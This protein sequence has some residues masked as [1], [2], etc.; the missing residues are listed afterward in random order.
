MYLFPYFTKKLMKHS[1][2]ILIYIYSFNVYSQYCTPFGDCSNGDYISSFSFNGI[3]NTSNGCDD[4]SAGYSNTGISFNADLGSSY[5][6][7]LKSGETWEQ[8]F[9]I[10]I[11]YNQDLDFD[12]ENE[13]VYRTLSASTQEFSGTITIAESAT[14]GTTRMRVRSQYGND[15]NSGDACLD[16][17]YGET[18]DYEIV[19]SSPSTPPDADFYANTTSTCSGTIL[20]FDNSSNNPTNWLWYFGDGNT[21]SEQNPSHTYLS[22]GNYT[23]SLVVENEFGR[24][25]IAQKDYINVN[26]FNALPK[27]ATCIPITKN[28]ND[29]FGI[30]KVEFNTI[31]N[32]SGNA[33][34][35]YEDFT[36]FSTTVLTGKYYDIN[37]VTDYPLPHNVKVWIDFNDDGSFSNGE[38]VIDSRNALV[39]NDSIEIPSLVVLDT[40]LRM[41]VSADF[42]QQ[43]IPEPCVDLENGQAEDYTII[44]EE[45][46]SPPICKF[47]VSEAQ[48]CDGS[49]NFSDLSENSPTY[50]FWDFG[51]GSTSNDVNPL[52]TY[53]ESGIYDVK[54]VTGNNFGTDTL[55]KE[56]FVTVNFNGQLIEASCNPTTTSPF[57]SYGIFGVSF[58]DINN[59]SG[60]GEENYQDYSC[61]HNT[62]IGKSGCYEITVRTGPENAEDVNVWIDFDNNGEFNQTE[63]VFA[64]TNQFIHSGIINISQE[65]PVLDTPLRMRVSSDFTGSNNGPCDNVQWGQVEDYALVIS[66]ENSEPTVFFSADVTETCDGG[67]QFTDESCGEP[68]AW[69]WVFG[70]GKTSNEQNPFHQY[71]SPGKYSVTLK[72]SNDQGTSSYQITNYINVISSLGSPIETSCYP[73]TTNPVD[74]A[75]IFKVKF[76]TIDYSTAG[77]GDSYEDYT[78]EQQAIVAQGQNVPISVNTGNDWQ[79]DVR[80]WID[81]NNDGNFITSELVFSS[82]SKFG[83]HVGNINIPPA[84]ITDIPLRMRILSDITQGFSYNACSEPEFGQIEDYTVIIQGQ[85]DT[86]IASFYAD[87]ANNCFGNVAFT[88]T[89]SIT[90]TSFLWE[91]GDG[92]T[93]TEFSPTHSYG[94]PGAYTVRLTASNNSGTNTMTRFNYI[95]YYEDCSLLSIPEFEDLVYDIFP[96]PSNGLYHL[97]LENDNYEKFVV[98]IFDA[99]GKSIF[100]E[101]INSSFHTFDLS[102]QPSGFY[103]MN[104]SGNN[105]NATIK[106]IKR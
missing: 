46:T 79:H 26:L 36:C 86:P 28:G 14:S 91:F 88:N 37:I 98:T 99:Y 19:I 52:H 10:W 27:A 96:N 71:E 1:L 38:Q 22:D 54:L 106:I 67:I 48:T 104:L 15:F 12:D 39:T 6:I 24:D 4:F 30:T 44:I 80:V 41:R 42:F 49:I 103:L 45:N 70:D 100:R 93:S 61:E 20:F 32:N 69:Y 81:Y 50:W 40:P 62:V 74:E 17:A 53:V 9:S 18:E 21:S 59:S 43:N 29:G 25:S 35:G 84:S 55:L 92:N 83:N 82:N 64:S 90:A 51:D 89:S 5:V 101:I 33:S 72:A 57:G 76:Y 97:N 85:N 13:L 102:E 7:T 47:D 8:G 34:A 105:N 77:S 66:A 11:D 60:G 75:G 2:F 87:S 65:N 16:V 56:Q 63:L 78:C 23:V 31:N 73:A 95:Q 3:Y 58:R 94:S 68:T